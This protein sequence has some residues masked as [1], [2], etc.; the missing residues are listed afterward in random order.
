M[1][2]FIYSFLVNTYIFDNLEVY[3][4]I[5][6]FNTNYLYI[7]FIMTYLTIHYVYKCIYVRSY[8]ITTY[9][10]E[11]PVHSMGGNP[12]VSRPPAL[13]HFFLSFS[14]LGPHPWHM[15]V[16]KLS[17]ESELHLSAYTTATATP[18]PRPTER[19]WRSNPH[20]HGY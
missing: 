11:K 16:P 3:V 17:S 1:N 19:G 18:D 15:E 13:F 20:P 14:F 5:N 10:F 7:Q 4:G 2:L 9:Y 12:L 6:I 8:V